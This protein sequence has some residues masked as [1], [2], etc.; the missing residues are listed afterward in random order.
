LC[1]AGHRPKVGRGPF[2]Q[3]TRPL[4]RT[5][6]LPPPSTWG[7]GRPASRRGFRCRTGDK[8]VVRSW[9]FSFRVRASTRL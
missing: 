7:T 1:E 8:E 2:R 3:M 6:T 9:R 5:P 4:F